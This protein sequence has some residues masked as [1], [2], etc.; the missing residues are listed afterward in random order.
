M[1]LILI[2]LADALAL[3]LALLDAW[4]IISV[5]LALQQPKRVIVVAS[6]S[7]VIGIRG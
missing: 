1:K 6:V 2:I 3:A 4:L 5:A 7:A